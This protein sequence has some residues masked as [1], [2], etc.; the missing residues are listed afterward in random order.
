M[1]ICI[2][3]NDEVLFSYIRCVLEVFILYSITTSDFTWMRYSRVA[4]IGRQ[5]E[6]M[7]E[8]TFSSA[9]PSSTLDPRLGM[10]CLRL[11]G[12]LERTSCR[13][14][15]RADII[16]NIVALANTVPWDIPFTTYDHDSPFHQ[17]NSAAFLER[18]QPMGY[19]LIAM[20]YCL[21][22]EQVVD[23]APPRCSNV[24]VY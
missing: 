20:A 2:A 12:L 13:E 7:S 1:E 15:C 23:D 19:Y 8:I 3:Q 6:L 9:R 16:R 11:A 17:L 22:T 14:R 24:Y 10:D 4:R 5:T 18:L 21:A